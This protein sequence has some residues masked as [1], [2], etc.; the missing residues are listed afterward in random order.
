MDDREWK[1][2]QEEKYG[3]SMKQKEDN[4]TWMVCMNIGSLPTSNQHYKNTEICNLLRAHKVDILVLA[5]KYQL[6]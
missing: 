5:E 1:G 2:S 3:D 4:T 6:E